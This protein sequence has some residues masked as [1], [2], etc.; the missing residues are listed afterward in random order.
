MDS[1]PQE[2]TGVVWER[3]VAA[4]ATVGSVRDDFCKSY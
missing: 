3:P 4:I 2:Y 1:L